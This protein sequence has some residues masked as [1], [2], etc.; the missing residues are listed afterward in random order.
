MILHK[1]SEGASRGLTEGVD[2]M[3]KQSR[4]QSSGQ[5]Y[6][7]FTKVSFAGLIRRTPQAAV[8][9]VAIF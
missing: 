4:T 1:K 6:F 8:Q 5:L 2:D 7:Y 9:P 3:A